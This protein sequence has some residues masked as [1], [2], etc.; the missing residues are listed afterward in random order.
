MHFFLQ[1]LLLHINLKETV[2]NSWDTL[3]I[4][5]GNHCVLLTPHSIYVE[6]REISW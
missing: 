4:A 6:L 2:E 3:V 5:V 1:T